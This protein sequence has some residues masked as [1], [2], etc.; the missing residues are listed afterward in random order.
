[1]RRVAW[2]RILGSALVVVLAA[3]LFYAIWSP[4][5]QEAEVYAYVGSE[6]VMMSELE[7][8][9][10]SR[11]A[12]QENLT[13]REYFNES[14]AP[15]TMIV[16]EARRLG[17]EVNDS[18]VDATVRLINASLQARNESFDSYLE[19]LNATLP[20]LRRDI[21]TSYLLNRVIEQEIA[22]KIN[23]SAAEV[24]EAYEAGGYESLGIPLEQAR[25]EIG[26]RIL[27]QK[28]NE[29]LREYVDQLRERYEIRYA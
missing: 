25:N 3:A 23:V 26:P 14:Y 19:Q 27:Q 12:S 28:Q 17:I 21:R 20:Q 4:S 8:A 16:L 11:D 5:A 22:A 18:E 10:T 7:R 13:L 29:R 15:R 6:P 9:Y 2:T 24:Q 1:M